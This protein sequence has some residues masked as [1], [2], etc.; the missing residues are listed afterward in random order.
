M[1]Q[2]QVPVFE[3]C[4]ALWQ[5]RTNLLDLVDLDLADLFITLSTFSLRSGFWHFAFDLIFTISK[6]YTVNF[7]LKISSN[8][9]FSVPFFP[10]Q[11]SF[12]K[13]ALKNIT[14]IRHM[15]LISLLS[16]GRTYTCGVTFYFR[17]ALFAL[18]FIYDV[19]L[20]GR[21]FI[22]WSHQFSWKFI[23]WAEKSVPLACAVQ[24]PSSNFS[25][26]RMYKCAFTFPVSF[27]LIICRSLKETAY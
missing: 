22:F 13:V 9:F 19:F 2:E 3:R 24:C 25:L 7:F 6:I 12:L 1:L 11:E 17:K 21:R 18:F 27:P 10:L 15:Q 4:K 23:V 26:S 20:D 5:N 8:K 16:E 14:N